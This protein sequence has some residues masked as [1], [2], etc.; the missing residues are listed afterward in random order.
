MDMRV[1]VTLH[2]EISQKQV[3]SWVYIVCGKMVNGLNIYSCAVLKCKVSMV[4][5]LD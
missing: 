2:I 4:K 5:C 3:M 1:P